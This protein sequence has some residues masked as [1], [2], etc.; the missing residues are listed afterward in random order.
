MKWIQRKYKINEN[1]S[2]IENVEGCGIIFEEPSAEYS[3][4]KEQPMNIK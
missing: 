3:I 4:K 2:N 1:D